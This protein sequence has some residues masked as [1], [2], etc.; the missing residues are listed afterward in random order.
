MK[1][2][3]NLT[4]SSEFLKS[5]EKKRDANKAAKFWMDISGLFLFSGLFVTGAV[6]LT[7]FVPWEAVDAYLTEVVKWIFER[8]ES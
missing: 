6:A 2:S 8:L 5:L 3:N 7:V 4:F 1:N